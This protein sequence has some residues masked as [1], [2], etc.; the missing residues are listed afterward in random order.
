MRIAERNNRRRKNGLDSSEQCFRFLRRNPVITLK[1]WFLLIAVVS[2]VTFRREFIRQ[3]QLG[4]ADND[5]AIV[6]FVRSRFMVNQGNLTTLGNARFELFKAFTYPSMTKQTNQSFLWLILTDPNLVDELKQPLLDLLRPHS[7]IVVL[8][9]TIKHSHLFDRAT[10]YDKPECFGEVWTDN[11]NIFANALTKAYVEEAETIFLDTWLD[12]DDAVYLHFVRDVHDTAM[13]HLSDHPS[14]RIATCPL[15]H[16]LWH[17]LPHSSDTTTIDEKQPEVT[18][19]FKT[20]VKSIS[21]EGLMQR[22]RSTFCITAGLTAGFG[23]SVRPHDPNVD[24]SMAE[25][26][27]LIRHRPYCVNETNN[28]KFLYSECLIE[29]QPR[30]INH[31]NHRKNIPVSVRA[32]C[33]TST[34]M[35]GVFLDYESELNK[36]VDLK[37]QQSMWV[38][39]ETRF[40]LDQRTVQES[41]DY[42]QSNLAEMT[43]EN[44]A[45][46]VGNAHMTNSHMKTD[47]MKTLLTNLQ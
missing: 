23:A 14:R 22:R 31:D 13:E 33:P 4:S 10:C 16:I 3:Q 42:L 20:T 35:G 1:K 28:N 29:L 41:R 26:R 27:N 32:R 18:S 43:R 36:I 24:W 19:T 25:H 6:H 30:P 21:H 5:A 15:E 37:D 7:N 45:G 39:V 2:F 8:A 47:R 34:G 38:E 17:F 12:A 40:G 46:H 9:T 11:Y 44:I